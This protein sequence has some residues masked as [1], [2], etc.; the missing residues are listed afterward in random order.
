MLR[1]RPL[2]QLTAQVA[3]P[4]VTPDGPYG[5]RRY[6]P[7]IGG[8]FKGDRL[9]GVLLPG[10]ADCQLI[11]P[12]L[13]AELDVRVTLRTDDGAVVF[14]KGLGIRHAAPEVAARLLAGEAVDRTE[15]YFR[16][17]MQFEAPPG[18]YSW[19]N[20]I[21]AVGVGERLPDAVR[22]EAFEIL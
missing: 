2:F 9:S 20:T 4:H 14:M 12:D 19:M 6:I 7:V 11:R 17:A 15:Y 10:G 21:I 5:V 1:S 13:T 22:I 18:K 8:A 16:E 3:E